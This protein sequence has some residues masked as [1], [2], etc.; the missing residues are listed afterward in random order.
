MTYSKELLQKMKLSSALLEPPASDV[1][2]ELID[3]IDRLNTE[4]DRLNAA[5]E[6]VS[7]KEAFPE[8]D[9]EYLVV[10]ACRTSEVEIKICSFTKYQFKNINNNSFYHSEYQ[11]NWGDE[12]FE[13]GYVTHW[14]PLPTPPTEGENGN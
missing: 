10:D 7:V 9:G 13:N 2:C 3:E 11:Q 5:N 12:L 6:W 8:R 14:Q 1:V 4:N